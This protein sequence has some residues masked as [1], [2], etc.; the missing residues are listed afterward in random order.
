MK[1][2]D[3]FT[4]LEILVAL[5]LFA[6]LGGVLLQLFHSGLRNT[7]IATEHTHAA[8]LARSKLNELLAYE[9]LQPGVFDGELANGY[10]WRSTLSESEDVSAAGTLPGLLE[11]TI[12]IEWGEP[13]DERTVSLNSLLLSR[14]SG[15]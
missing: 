3:G 13:G 10:R 8:L 11:L 4:L 9:D 6:V 14:W 2:A 12:E 15:R 5:T 7:R 1:R